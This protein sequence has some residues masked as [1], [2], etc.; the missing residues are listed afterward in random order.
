MELA[1]ASDGTAIREQWEVE[2]SRFFRYPSS[3]FSIHPSLQPLSS[4]QRNRFSGTW[5]SSS[6]SSSHSLASLKLINS[7]RHSI[8]LI[9]TFQHKILEEHYISK[10]HFTWPQ[11]SCVSGYP[12]RGSKVVLLSYK[13]YAG[14]IQKFALRFLTINE[15]EKFI[16]SLKEILEDASAAGLPYSNLGSAISSQ[17]E[18]VPPLGSPYKPSKD[19]S[20]TASANTYPH[21]MSS[22]LNQDAA[23]EKNIQGTIHN[24]QVEG[25]L[26][27]FPPSFTS[28]LMNC[29]P[30]VE[31]AA[32]EPTVSKDADLKVQ[33]ARYL[34]DSS[35]QD[36]LTKVEKVISEMGDDLLL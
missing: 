5:I 19:W 1:I 22:S 11:V 24:H 2:Y 21:E 9:I 33:I 17:S 35:F 25:V 16:N 3:L 20:P 18:C 30:S 6:S 27:S 10:L 14:Q 13:D 26:S 12:A 8:I 31:Q 32:A 7:D 36:M 28:L 15:T 29:C 34:E 23:Q 4:A